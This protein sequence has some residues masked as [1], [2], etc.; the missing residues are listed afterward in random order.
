MTKSSTLK[1]TC[2]ILS[3]NSCDAEGTS[4]TGRDVDP[5]GEDSTAILNVGDYIPVDTA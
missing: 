5:E 1:S 3:F 2:D 4:L